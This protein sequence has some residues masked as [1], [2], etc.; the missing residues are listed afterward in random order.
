MNQR[1]LLCNINISF[2]IAFAIISISIFIVDGAW[3]TWSAWATCDVSCGG[4]KQTRSRTCTNPTPAHGGAQCLGDETESQTCNINQC[5]GIFLSVKGIYIY[6]T[7][8]AQ[9]DEENSS[10]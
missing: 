10:I 8:P 1:F 6:I 7:A 4:G 2:L 9:K 3:A 5:K